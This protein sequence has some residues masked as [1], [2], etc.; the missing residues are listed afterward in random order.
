MFLR[1]LIFLALLG[2]AWFIWKK[3]TTA[4]AVESDKRDAFQQMVQCRTCG[5]HLPIAEAITDEEQHHFCCQE[6]VGKQR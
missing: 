6:H 1:L 5:V 4:G 3:V 2:A